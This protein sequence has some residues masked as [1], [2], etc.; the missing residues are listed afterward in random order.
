MA[1]LIFN[2]T[3]QEAMDDFSVIPVGYYNAQVVKSDV[4]PTKAKTG[5]RM[6]L[7]FKII[8]G[9]YKG[10]IIFAG[11]N[12]TNPNEVA[13]EISR[14]EIK[15]LCDAIG[16]P[17]GIRDTTELHNIPLQIKLKIVP[18]NGQYAAKNEISFYEP[19]EGVSTGSE[20]SGE[21][22]QASEGSGSTKPEWAQ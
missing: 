20:V 8:D 15:S 1:E 11:Y 4:V 21:F 18:E 16:K 12:I 10:R 9:D 2:G 19:Y 7:Q 17:D 14:K 5:T 22:I 6:N 13:V 3:N